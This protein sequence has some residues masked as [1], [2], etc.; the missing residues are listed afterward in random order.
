MS[1]FNKN[2]DFLFNSL[3]N[4][5]SQFEI[6]D[7]ISIEKLEANISNDN[8]TDT[9]NILFNKKELKFKLPVKVDDI[10][11][12][13]LFYQSQAEFKLGPLLFN[14]SKQLLISEDLQVILRHSH[15][16]MLNEIM[17]NKKKGISKSKLY[18]KL[19]PKDVNIQMNKLD[20][21]LTN[22]KKVIYESFNYEVML[23]T[24]NGKLIIIN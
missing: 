19:W 24:I 14:P 21:H 16:K 12:E 3:E 9:L 17:I 1:D 4:L 10:L 23:K 15:N 22:L 11:R 2:R 18:E 8:K 6:T 7:K 13:L 20:T 5:L